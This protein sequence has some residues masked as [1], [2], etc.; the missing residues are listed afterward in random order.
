MTLRLDFL[1]PKEKF[2][3]VPNLSIFQWLLGIKSDVENFILGWFK[4]VIEWN[5]EIGYRSI[6]RLYFIYIVRVLPHMIFASVLSEGAGLDLI[7]LC[8][9]TLGF[10]RNNREILWSEISYLL[11]AAADV[12]SFYYKNQIISAEAA[13][14]LTFRSPQNFSYDERMH[15]SW[16]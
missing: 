8:S 6:M 9:F 3:Y 15:G 2:L 4:K 7:S 10:Q 13:R 16:I 5:L 14:F 1:S 12:I 11:Q